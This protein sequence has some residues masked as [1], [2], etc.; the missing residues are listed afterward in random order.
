MADG[1]KDRTSMGCLPTPYKRIGVEKLREFAAASTKQTGERASGIHTNAHEL[2]VPSKGA[3]RPAGGSRIVVVVLGLV[4]CGRTIGTETGASLTL[5]VTQGKAFCPES[6]G[7]C[8]GGNHPAMGLTASPWRP[9]STV[10]G[11]WG[12][13]H[14]ETR[15]NLVA[16]Q[17][18]GTGVAVRFS[19]NSVRYI[20][21]QSHSRD[22]LETQLW[23]QQLQ[24]ERRSVHPTSVP[25]QVNSKHGSSNAGQVCLLPP[26]W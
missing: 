18:I 25:V 13:G 9:G 17:S 16:R 20:V 4:W 14:V 12:V 15:L 2:H 21:T 6:P 1:D 10:W 23:V 11:T 7:G 24:S 5:H 26:C 22:T 8:V 3:L 19:E